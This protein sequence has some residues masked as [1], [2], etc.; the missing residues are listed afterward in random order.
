MDRPDAHKDPGTIGRD[1]IKSYAL[2][3]VSCRKG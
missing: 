1:V 3:H 2:L